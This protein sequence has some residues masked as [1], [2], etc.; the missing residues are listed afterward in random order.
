M[1]HDRDIRREL[2]LLLESRYANDSSTIIVNE[3]GVCGGSARV[4]LA[5]V[6]SHLAGYEIKS[7]LDTLDR[8]DRQL[9]FYSRVFDCL[10]L[11]ASTRHIK[12][13]VDQLP[14]WV[15]VVAAFANDDSLRLETVRE[16]SANPSIEPYAVAQLLW[17]DEALTLL[18]QRNLDV[19]L[20][21]KPR[22]AVWG[23]L[24]EALP[25]EELRLLVRETLKTRPNWL[26]DRQPRQDGDWCPTHAT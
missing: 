22:K 21:T 23:R 9:Q 4:D 18:E 13:L 2:R 5:V 16:E 3:L 10:T 7:E 1:M 15:G 17:R 14:E 25:E 24:A 19:G 8:L 12:A 26:P 20:R 6:N 11:V